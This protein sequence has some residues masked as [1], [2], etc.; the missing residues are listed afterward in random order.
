[1]KGW[2]HEHEA[3]WRR[4]CEE[5]T[6]RV[7]DEE[8]GPI[9]RDPTSLD[10]LEVARVCC[11]TSVDPE[12]ELLKRQKRMRDYVYEYNLGDLD[13]FLSYFKQDTP[14]QIENARAELAKAR[15]AAERI[16][17]EIQRRDFC[18]QPVEG[19]LHWLP[20]LLVEHALQ[21]P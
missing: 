7:L 16:W 17:R 15:I 14:E 4:R 5:T 19:H 8:F 13:E 21:L 3:V 2:T 12:N 18:D 11:D 10:A 6:I 20:E 1:M 9:P